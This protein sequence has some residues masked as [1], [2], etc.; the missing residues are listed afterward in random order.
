MPLIKPTRYVPNFDYQRTKT[1]NSFLQDAIDVAKTELSPTHPLRL[2]LALNISIFYYEILNLPRQASIFA[3]EAL[4]DALDEFDSLSNDSTKVIQL[5][6]NFLR[7]A[8]AKKELVMGVLTLCASE[9]DQKESE[10]TTERDA[11]AYADGYQ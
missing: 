6:Q 4:D 8:R 7:E 11:S 2:G 1:K 3:Q 5:L 10:G 9:V